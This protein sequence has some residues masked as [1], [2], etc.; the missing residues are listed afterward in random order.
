[1]HVDIDVSRRQHQA[2]RTQRELTRH[3]QSLVGLLHRERQ[4][5]ALHGSAVDRQEQMVARPSH[6]AGLANQSLDAVARYLTLLSRLDTLATDAK[7]TRAIRSRVDGGQ[8]VL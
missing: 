8:C 5:A 7:L 4:A 3:R 2:E 6:G 1:M